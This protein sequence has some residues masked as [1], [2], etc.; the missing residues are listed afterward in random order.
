MSQIFDFGEQVEGYAVKVL[1]ERELRAGAGALF[2]VTFIS[3]VNCIV[4][5]NIVIMETF[6]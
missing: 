5:K 2:L 1:N 4:M 3:F 6:L